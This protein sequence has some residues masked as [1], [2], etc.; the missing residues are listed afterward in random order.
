MTL[1]EWISVF[2]AFVTLA[3]QFMQWK[4]NSLNISPGKKRHDKD[5]HA[6]PEEQEYVEYSVADHNS[7]LQNCK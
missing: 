2:I 1:F 3:L 6:I 7:R 4:N 5:Q